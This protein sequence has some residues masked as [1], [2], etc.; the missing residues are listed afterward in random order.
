[1]KEHLAYNYILDLV[2]TDKKSMIVIEVIILI[3]TIIS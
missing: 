1:M 3:I 2:F